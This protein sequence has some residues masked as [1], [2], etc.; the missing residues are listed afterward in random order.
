M[1][2]TIV[3]VSTSLLLSAVA[4]AEQ[5]PKTIS[6]TSIVGNDETPKS[7]YIVPWKS[8]ELGVESGLSA[9]LVDDGLEPVDRDVFMRQLEFYEISRSE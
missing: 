8:S 1:R 3:V 9:D 5:E 2:R 7:L 4:A 6:G